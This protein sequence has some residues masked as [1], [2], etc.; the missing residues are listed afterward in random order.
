MYIYVYIY[1]YT[2]MYIYIDIYICLPSS[3]K[4]H[5]T[6]KSSLTIILSG[7]GTGIIS[8]PLRPSWKRPLPIVSLKEI[9]P[10][11]NSYFMI[12]ADSECV[13]SVSHLTPRPS[14]SSK[15]PAGTPFT[16]V[17]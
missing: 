7:T 6:G 1:I 11:V 12:V 16:F 17:L 13:G 5:P 14:C 4:K 3:S 9:F 15:L 8:P 2:Y 10:V